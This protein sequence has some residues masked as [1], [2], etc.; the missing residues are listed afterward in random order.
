MLTA[1]PTEDVQLAIA[2]VDGRLDAFLYSPMENMGEAWAGLVEKFA[3]LDRALG[4]ELYAAAQREDEVR[5]TFPAA[6]SP[7]LPPADSEFAAALLELFLAFCDI[8]RRSQHYLGFTE[9]VASLQAALEK[10]MVL[11]PR[12]HGEIRTWFFD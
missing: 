12:Y 6:Q 1:K 8:R 11:C 10:V 7:S 4:G 5:W 2:R 3:E 9:A